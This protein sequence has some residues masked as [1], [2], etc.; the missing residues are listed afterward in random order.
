MD[1]TGLAIG[2]TIHRPVKMNKM[3]MKKTAKQESC[4]VSET[5]SES[6]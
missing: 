4:L 1:G 6:S 3:M 2:G 5:G